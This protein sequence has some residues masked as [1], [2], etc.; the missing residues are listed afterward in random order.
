MRNPTEKPLTFEEKQI[1]V[2]LYRIHHGDTSIE[3]FLC[4]PEKSTRFVR[5]FL[6]AITKDRFWN[7]GEMLGDEY[8]H[9]VLNTLI[10]L[11]KYGVRFRVRS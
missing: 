4:Q 1:L 9:P 6:A 10:R 8:Y 11:R 5:R 7:S 3:Q 2:G